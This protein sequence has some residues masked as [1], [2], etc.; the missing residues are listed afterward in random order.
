MVARRAHN[1][2]VGG[3]NPSPATTQFQNESRLPP[4]GFRATREAHRCA[5]PSRPTDPVRLRGRQGRPVVRREP[6]PLGAWPAAGRDDPGD[7]PAAGDPARVAGSGAASTPMGSGATRQGAG[8][9][10]GVE[11]QRVPVLH[12]SRT[13][14]CVDI[15]DIVAEP[16]VVIAR[17]RRSCRAS[18]TPCPRRRRWPTRTTSRRPPGANDMTIKPMPALVDLKF[19]IGCITMRTCSATRWARCNGES[20]LLPR[21]KGL[22]PSTLIAWDGSVQCGGLLRLPSEPRRKGRRAR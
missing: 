13:A 11:D 2:K 5:S 12:E 18:G 17:P 20:P 8:H 6:R 1:P 7:V 14:T 21:R 9:H 4:G 15:A 19:L 10:H 22:R 16:L 3:S